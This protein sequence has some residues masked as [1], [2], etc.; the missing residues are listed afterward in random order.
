M[1]EK[2]E[3]KNDKLDN[4]SVVFLYEY[5]R[6]GSKEVFYSVDPGLSDSSVKRTEQAVCR[7]WR[8][9]SSVIELDYKAKPVQLQGAK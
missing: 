2:V 4:P 6:T 3:L 5:K 7:V 8:N 9:P 1:S